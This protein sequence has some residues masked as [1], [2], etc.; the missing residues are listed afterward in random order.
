MEAKLQYTLESSA[1]KEEL[2]KQMDVIEASRV[3]EFARVRDENEK[4]E[5][6][7]EDIRRANAAL[8]AKVSTLKARARTTEEHL[9]QEEFVRDAVVGE[10]MEKVVADFQRSKEYAALLNVECD[11]GYERGVEE[12]FFTIWRKPERG[13]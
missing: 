2:R 3:E 11:V 12:I 7:L 6:E 10:A 13:L 1:R 4:L 5:G 8:T 9:A